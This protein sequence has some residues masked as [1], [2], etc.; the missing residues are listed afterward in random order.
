MKSVYI[1]EAKYLLLEVRTTTC[2]LSSCISHN[3]VSTHHGSKVSTARGQYFN[4][5]AMMSVHITEAQ[6]LLLEVSFTTLSPCIILS[7]GKN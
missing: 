6:Y 3:D 2:T 1:T 4:S 7:A 5:D